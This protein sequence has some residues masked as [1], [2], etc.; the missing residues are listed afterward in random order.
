MVRNGVRQDSGGSGSD[1][2]KTK[3]VAAFDQLRWR[4]DRI[5]DSN[6][7]MKLGEYP[8]FKS[9]GALRSA[10]NRASSRSKE[11]C[12]RNRCKSAPSAVEVVLSRVSSATRKAA[13]V[14]YLRGWLVTLL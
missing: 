2:G 4:N 13:A 7:Q 12:L 9:H 3:P 10:N 11:T 5:T 6:V 8:P 14:A 1:A